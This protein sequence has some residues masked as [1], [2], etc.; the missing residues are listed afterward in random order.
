VDDSLGDR[1]VVASAPQ[2]YVSYIGTWLQTRPVYLVSFSDQVTMAGF[3]LDLIKD[4]P[5]YV[6]AI[7]KA[8]S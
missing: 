2:Q 1:V 4:G 7:T 3:H 6:Y 5:Y 8:R